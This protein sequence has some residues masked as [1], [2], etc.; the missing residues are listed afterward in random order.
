MFDETRPVLS[1]RGYPSARGTPAGYGTIGTKQSSPPQMIPS[2]VFRQPRRHKTHRTGSASPAKTY[3]LW[4]E[5]R[6]D[7]VLRT[8]DLLAASMTCLPSRPRAVFS[9]AD[10]WRRAACWTPHGSAV[11]DTM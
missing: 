6:W 8:V 2:Q 5:S 9:A 7:A 4:A 11:F 1:L 10:Y 3:S